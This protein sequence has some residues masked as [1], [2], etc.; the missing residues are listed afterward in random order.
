MYVITECIV[1]VCMYVSMSVCL[2]VCLSVCMYVYMY[3]C[4]VKSLD[5]L[6]H[7]IELTGLQIQVFV[8]VVIGA[9]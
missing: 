1:Y 4:G 9:Q 5:F 2:S 7:I 8:V 3:V 6:C